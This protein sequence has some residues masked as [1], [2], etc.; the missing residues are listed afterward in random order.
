V[1]GGFARRSLDGRA[2]HHCW[3][4]LR[5]AERQGY[6]RRRGRSKPPGGPDEVHPEHPGRSTKT[7]YGEVVSV[8]MDGGGP[9]GVQEGADVDGHARSRSSAVEGGPNVS[10]EQQQPGLEGARRVA[11][12]TRCASPP[13]KVATSRDS[14]KPGSPTASSSSST[15]CDPASLLP[16]A[17][18]AQPVRDVLPRTSR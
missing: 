15:R 4:R 2:R 14:A 5:H 9:E 12:A 6:G 3:A 1:L 16:D 7:S 8:T 10:F 17:R 11:S 18:D 13:D